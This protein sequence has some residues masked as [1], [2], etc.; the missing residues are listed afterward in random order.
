MQYTVEIVTH[1]TRGDSYE[2][3]RVVAS[4]HEEA[5]KRAC[6]LGIVKDFQTFRVVPVK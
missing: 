2:A 6:D 3:G 1:I 4:S 5:S